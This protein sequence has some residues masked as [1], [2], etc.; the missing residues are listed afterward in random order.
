MVTDHE[1]RQR[2]ADAMGWAD[3]YESGHGML[4][5]TEPAADLGYDA[6]RRVGIMAPDPLNSN[7]DAAL[8]RAWC[9]GQGIEVYLEHAPN[10]AGMWIA[11][12]SL[13]RPNSAPKSRLLG[14]AN[15]LQQEEPDPCRRE[16][17]S[18]CRAVLEAL[19]A[20]GNTNE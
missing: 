6:P 10:R 20:G 9:V 19:E 17:L 18:L 15:V 12:C 11:G 14:M 7:N 3:M 4:F 8:L 16:R 1:M 5:G 13:V 2:L